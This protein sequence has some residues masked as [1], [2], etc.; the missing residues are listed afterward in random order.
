MEENQKID[1]PVHTD[2][3]EKKQR[4]N[5]SSDGTAKKKPFKKKN[6][7]G[8]LRTNNKKEKF[9]R[10]Q[11]EENEEDSVIST[12]KPI[13]NELFYF[14]R[15]KFS[16]NKTQFFNLLD[17]VLKVMDI[18]DIKEGNMTLFSYCAMY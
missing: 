14:L 18:K 13:F 16:Y 8:H 2:N 1:T 6:F 12:P 9:V 10:P 17:D 15:Q 7:N 4:T 3:S 5:T 11:E